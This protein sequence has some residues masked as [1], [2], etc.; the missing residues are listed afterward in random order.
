LQFFQKQLYGQPAA[1]P[2][3]DCGG[4]RGTPLPT[5]AATCE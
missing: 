3:E 5:R 2:K 1:R 4:G